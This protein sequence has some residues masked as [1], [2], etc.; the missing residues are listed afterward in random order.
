MAGETLFRAVVG[1]GD[2]RLRSLAGR[3]GLITA[4][5]T[6]RA[7][8]EFGLITADAAAKIA[9]GAA[10][11]TTAAAAAFRATAFGATTLGPLG[12]RNS[13]GAAGR[14]SHRLDTHR[15][16]TRNI[17]RHLRARRI[18]TA[19]LVAFVALVAA[20]ATMAALARLAALVI[21]T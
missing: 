11:A 16:L 14:F 4:R 21:A 6:H 18:V 3:C 7:A 15:L 5:T 2:G 12:P 10:F 13:F 20:I 19:H 9:T 8:Q 1:R 17:T